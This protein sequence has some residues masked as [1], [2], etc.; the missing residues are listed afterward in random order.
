MPLDR[1]DFEEVA[2]L[3]DEWNRR[4]ARRRFFQLY[5]DQDEPQPDGTVIHARARYPKHMEFFEAG[6]GYRE[7][8]LLAANRTGK[9]ICGAYETTVHLTGL[10]PDWWPGRRFDHPVDWWAAG[11][12]NETTRDI[13]QS[14]LVGQVREKGPRKLITG[15]GLIPGSLLGDPTWKAGVPD[16]VDT[17]QVRHATGGWSQLGLKAYQQGRGSFEGTTRHGV[18]CDEEPPADVYGECLIR[19]ATV[20]GI[21]MLTFTPL[22]G[23]S[24][25]VL[26]FLPAEQRPGG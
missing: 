10:Y 25:V 11:K 2:V 6:R 26:S 22:L 17:I 20:G 5:P 8:C 3:L 14:Y 9:T 7:R 13:V 1:T 15:T 4:E 24:E 21:I 16:L 12:T 18:W 23:M 19:T